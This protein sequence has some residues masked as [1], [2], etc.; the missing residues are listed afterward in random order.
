MLGLLRKD[1]YCMRKH[2]RELIFVSL[3]IIILAVA[4]AYSMEYGNLAKAI[5]ESK[6]TDGVSAEMNEELILGM[7]RYGVWMMLLV[8][9]ALVTNVADCFREDSKADFAKLGYCLP[10]N[11]L[12]LVGSRYL[13]TCIYIAV[14]VCASLLAA[15]LVAWRTETYTFSGLASVVLCFA[16]LMIVGVST[17]IVTLY[18]FGTRHFE[19][20]QIAELIIGGGIGGYLVL[21]KT[22]VFEKLEEPEATYRLIALL[23]SIKSFLESKGLLLFA[24][25]LGV[26]ALSY[27]VAVLIAKRRREV[28]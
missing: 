17:W 2:S 10:V 6:P 11:E 28:R 9:V 27:V 3:G 15:C 8:P 7:F 5:A 25:S 18:L 16:A 21:N 12:Q 23:D 22:G 1:L 19:M 13:T 14:A 24:V 26:L 20:L 4:F